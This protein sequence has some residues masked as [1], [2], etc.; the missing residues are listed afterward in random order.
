MGTDSTLA[1]F[2]TASPPP[3]RMS[4]EEFF[5]WHPESGLAEWV[6]GEAF[7]MAPP[8]TR[9]QQIVAFLLR[10]LGFFV[11]ARAL[12]EVFVAPVQMRLAKSGREPD[13]LFV[14][15]EN[16]GRIDG[17]YLHG[18]ADLAIE[19]VS[20]DSRKR[21][22][23]DKF[24]EY[25]EAGVPEYWIVDGMKKQATFYGLGADGSYH[26]LPVTSDNVFHSEVLAGLWL[27]VDWL[28]QEPLPQSISILKEWGLV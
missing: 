9:H 20:P 6:D 8:A 24:R 27:R 21:D 16:L 17:R 13:I 4:Y 26:A 23:V 22:Y 14:A 3:A 19:V 10:I 15:T 1:T 2:A 11:E 28:W 12:G 7:V 5:E 18:P 25:A